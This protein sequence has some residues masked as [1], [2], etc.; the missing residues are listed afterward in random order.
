MNSVEQ[1]LAI[2]EVRKLKL[3]FA[4]SLT[5]GLLCSKF[6]SI[7]GAS[8]VVLGSVVA[9]QNEVKRSLLGVRQN[10]LAARGA[11]SAE[12][13]TQMAIGVREKLS[14]AADIPLEQTISLATTGVAGPGAEGAI[15]AGTVFIALVA[16]ACDPLVKQFSFSGSRTEVR[17]AAAD[18]AIEMLR[19][20]L[21]G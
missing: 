9:Y 10:L 14:I 17:E 20:Y 12:V 5:G 7:A 13:A 1:I 3:A 18:A 4:E 21:A 16:P 2:L 8:N 11:V 15:A 19:D 6:V